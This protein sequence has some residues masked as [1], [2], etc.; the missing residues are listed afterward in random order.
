MNIEPVRRVIGKLIMAVWMIAMIVI[1]WSI[2]PV[3]IVQAQDATSYTVGVFT[4]SA[5]APTGTPLNEVTYPAGAAVCG[6]TPKAVQAP[7]VINPTHVGFD[8]P[9]NEAADC[10]IDIR[11]QVQKLK[12]TAYRISVKDNL[13]PY[14]GLTAPFAVRRPGPKNPRVR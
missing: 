14:E 10:E 9:A 7:Q 5:T 2:P 4:E 8:D 6:K 1:G 12:A 11:A 13:T 3:E